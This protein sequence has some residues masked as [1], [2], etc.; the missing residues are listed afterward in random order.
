METKDKF[1]KYLSQFRKFERSEELLI[2]EK[3]KL[4]Q[5]KRKDLYLK[6]G[7]KNDQLGF[8][9]KGVFRYFFYN[10][11]GEEITAHFMSRED[12]VGNVNCFFEYSISAG[13]IEALTECEVVQISKENWDE[14]K[15]SIE[16]WEVIFQKII[17]SVLIKKTNFQRSLLNTTA[18]ESYLI[19]LN[20]YPSLSNKVP[21]QYVASYL[22]MTPYSL[23]R[24]RRTI[25]T[26]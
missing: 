16:D 21:L 1:I 23:S 11:K 3:L 14:C 2:A 24:V 13:T 22:G 19:F 9:T 4:V 18:T 6:T 17:N 15:D 10:D 20:F 5:Y 7:E 26:I 8:I 25:S 12:L